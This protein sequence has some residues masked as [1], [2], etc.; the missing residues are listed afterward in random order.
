MN[1]QPGTETE[2]L[3]ASD[4]SRRRA[5][6]E[7][8]PAADRYFLY[9][10][11][12]TGVYCR[13]SCAARAARPEHV[14][15]HASRQDA[16]RAGFRPCKRC[17]PDLPP[18]SER[19][20]AIVARACRALEDAEEPLALAELAAQASLSPWHFHRVFKRVTGVTP[21]AYAAARRQHRA[22]KE[23][24]AGSPVTRAIYAAGFNSSGRFYEQA[25][26]LFEVA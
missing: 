25:A 4:A 2:Q 13:P 26:G 5:L 17:R 20:A 23:L 7:R 11:D 1:P 15:F 14:A 10:V 6:R 12:T 22:Q 8:N 24:A 3:F 21:R 9:S 19:E 18:R 16:E